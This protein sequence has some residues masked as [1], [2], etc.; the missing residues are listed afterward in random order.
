MKALSA[1]D[2]ERLRT[3]SLDIAATL[4]P[5]GTR[6]SDQGD[7]RVFDG[8]GG[9]SINRRSGLWYSHSQG[10]GGASPIGLI[11]H[12]GPTDGMRKFFVWRR[13]IL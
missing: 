10:R 1:A 8:T 6:W 2:F 9:L 7:E 13:T 11:W 5:P 12:L 4:L 3:W